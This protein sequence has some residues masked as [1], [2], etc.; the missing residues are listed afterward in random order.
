MKRVFRACQN[1]YLQVRHRHLSYSNSLCYSSGS[2]VHFQCSSRF[3]GV[4]QLHIPF[5][6][7]QAR[8]HIRLCTFIANAIVSTVIVR[9]SQGVLTSRKFIWSLTRMTG[10]ALLQ[11]GSI[12]KTFYLLKRYEGLIDTIFSPAS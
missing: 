1:S 12:W 4:F 2:S 7:Y 10:V 3:S 9:V 11:P 6:G 5:A 8:D